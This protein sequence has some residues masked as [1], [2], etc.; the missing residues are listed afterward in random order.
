MCSQEACGLVHMTKY[1]T[2]LF[3]EGPPFLQ[4]DLE[5]LSSLFSGIMDKPPSEQIERACFFRSFSMS[6]HH[7]IPAPG[8]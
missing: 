8:T 2:A 1:V 5:V 3:G 6:H 7:S 4:A